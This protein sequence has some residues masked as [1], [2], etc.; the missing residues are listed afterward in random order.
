M[1]LREQGV[2]DEPAHIK[3]IFQWFVIKACVKTERLFLF[4]SIT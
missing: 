1:T 4:F 2:F 3:Q